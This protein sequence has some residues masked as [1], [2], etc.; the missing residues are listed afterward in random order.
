MRAERPETHAPKALL[1]ERLASEVDGVFTRL[2]RGS[3]PME[4]QREGDVS[5]KINVG[6]VFQ[7]K[8]G[9]SARSWWRACS[10]MSQEMAACAPWPDALPRQTL[11][12][13]SAREPRNRGWRKSIVPGRSNS[14]ICFMPRSMSGRWRRPSLVAPRPKRWPGPRACGWLVHG[15]IDWLVTAMAALP[16]VAPPADQSTSVPH[17]A[18]TACRSAVAW[19]RPPAQGSSALA[20]GEQPCGEL[21]GL[22]AL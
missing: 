16:A 14:K 22:D 20:P 8:P 11:A 7:A 9:R 21:H 2:R 19:P 17:F 18:P 10:S 4:E 6:A 3:V 12:D 13:T 15:Q 5:R 1:I